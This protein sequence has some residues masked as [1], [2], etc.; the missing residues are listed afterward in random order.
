MIR[1]NRYL[2]IKRKDMVSALTAREIRRLNQLRRKV[3]LARRKAKKEPLVCVVVESD[4]PEYQPTWRAIE[5][6]V[7]EEAAGGAYSTDRGLRR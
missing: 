1:E 6:R 7:T 3:A 4:W 2:V 5:N